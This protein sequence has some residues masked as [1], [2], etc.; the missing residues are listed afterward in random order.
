MIDLDR[1][2]ADET[3]D[4]IPARWKSA[5]ALCGDD[6]GPAGPTPN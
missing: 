5:G 3:T 6:A 1:L 4:D 2:K